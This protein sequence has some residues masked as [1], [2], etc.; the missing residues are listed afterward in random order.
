[1]PNSKI[2]IF[3]YYPPLKETWNDFVAKSKNA[4]FLFNRSYMDYHVDRF[5]DASLMVYNDDTLIALFPANIFGDVA[6]S[7]GGL[8]YGGILSNERMTASK[9][10]KIFKEIKEFY[11]SQNCVKI[12]YKAIP[13]IYASIP[14]DEDLYAL[15]I[16]NAVFLK[17]EISSAILLKD[18]LSLSHGKKGN[19]AKAKKANL[20]IREV[21]TY[22]DFWK[23]LIN[24][25]ARHN[26]KPVH[27]LKEIELLHSMFPQNI[28]LFSAFKEDVMLA[29]VVIYENKLTTHTQYM[30]SSEIGRNHGALDAIIVHLLDDVYKNYQYFDFGISTESGGTYLNEGL[31]AQ[32]EMFG[33]RAVMYDT[34][35]ITL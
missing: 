31:I 6:I 9:M 8:T 27:S 11:K 24:I 10:L 1:M 7:H 22:V 29:G 23:I 35:E 30:A 33:G 21:D 3:A 2:K 18:R 12:V 17:R 19:I 28:R 26:A 14:A 13:Y 5:T 15:F 16:N 4:T 32:K 25:L 20:E 34:Y